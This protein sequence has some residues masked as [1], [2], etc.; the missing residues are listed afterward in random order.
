VESLKEPGS[1]RQGRRVRGHASVYDGVGEI[2]GNK[3]L[4]E[5]EDTRIFMDFGE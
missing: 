4:L 1:T 3:V 2:G 5:D